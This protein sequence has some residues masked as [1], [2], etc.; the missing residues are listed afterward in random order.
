MLGLATLL[1]VHK[2]YINIQGLVCLK[3]LFLSPLPIFL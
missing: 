2:E 3:S 1:V